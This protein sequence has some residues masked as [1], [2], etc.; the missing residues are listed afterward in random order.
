MRRLYLTALALVVLMTSVALGQTKHEFDKATY[1]KIAKRTIGS[2]LSGD[3]DAD[4]MLADVERLIELGVA[5]CREHEGE[6]ETPEAEKKIMRLT[7]DNAERMQGLTLEEIE[8]QWHEGGFLKEQGVD[9][10]KYDH[11]SEVM[12]HFDAVVH[13]ATCVICL[14]QY[15][16]TSDES[17][18]EELLEQVQAELEE[19]REHLKH[20]E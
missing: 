15:S 2:V 6:D 11:F 19:V 5:G 17:Q 16:K 13:P 8:A 12:C 4:K 14:K 9:L 20:L 18:R 3:V 10:D 1:D 7:V